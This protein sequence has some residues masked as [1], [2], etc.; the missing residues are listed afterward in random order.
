MLA[1]WKGHWIKMTMNVR[2]ATRKR[3]M[4]MSMKFMKVDS[5]LAF[6]V[7]EKVTGSGS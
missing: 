4:K 7:H 5:V 6:L 2:I 3:V 1:A